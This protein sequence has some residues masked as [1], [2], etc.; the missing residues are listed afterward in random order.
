MADDTPLTYEPLRE[1]WDRALFIAPHPDDIE[2]GGA[3]A[4][5]RWTRQGKSVIYTMVT[6]GEA[7]I[8]AIPPE[9][10][11]PLR[12]GEQRAAAEIVGVDVVE[13]L[14]FPDGT[15]EYG[16]PLRRELARAVRRHRPDIV[17]TGNHRETYGAGFLNQADHIAVGRAV[18]DGV[19]DAGNR[20][21][22]RDLLDDGLE[23]WGGVREVWMAGSP[24]S[25]HAVDTSDTFEVG[26]QSLHAHRE[27]IDGLGEGGDPTDFLEEIA[28]QAGI[29]LG[30]QYAV[31][32]E[33]LSP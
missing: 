14:G 20:W 10:A 9:E 22:F 29:R 21:V 8:D 23:P 26:M 3:A 1:D 27:Y 12:E 16:L 5:A 4:V 24:D 18:L 13:F 28:R 6:S 17:V 15:I 11:G 19:R 30:C 2:Y 32:F 25:R 33:V 7:G 31:P